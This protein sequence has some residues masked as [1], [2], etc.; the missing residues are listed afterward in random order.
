MLTTRKNTIMVLILFCGVIFLLGFE[1]GGFQLALFSA[2]N[3]LGFN[4]AFIGLPITMQNLSMSIMPLFFGALSDRIGKKPI[5]AI[6]MA[7]FVV[8]CFFAWSSDSALRFLIS[9]FILGLGYGVTECAVTSS[10][11]DSF[12][13]RE[14]KFLNLIH[15]FYCIGAV[16]SPLL[17]QFLIDSFSL[18]WRMIFLICAIIMLALLPILLFTRQVH[19]A[20]QIQK[21]A[22]INT[23]KLPVGLLFSFIICIFIYVGAEASIAF[24]ADTIFTLELGTQ[25]FGAYAISIFWG[26]MGIARF[27]F[28]RM[29]KVPTYTTAISLI[30]LAAIII[31]IAFA[32]QEIVM[33]V[34][35]AIAGLACSSIWPGIVNSSFALNRSASGKIMSFLN[36]GGGMGAALIPLA[37]GAIM[38]AASMPIAFLILTAFTIFAGLFMFR[39]LKITSQL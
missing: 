17:L 10:I 19:A 20:K 24:F 35:F 14:E 4:R 13:G 12:P 38:N 29:K 32:R 39:N 31:A 5:L 26:M 9:V 2:T 15:C 21:Q 30:C 27:C 33:L 18:S 22:Q 8:G 11:S 16:S 34:L 3:E 1:A 23:E 25:A 6:F 36:L 7:I 37:I 28:G